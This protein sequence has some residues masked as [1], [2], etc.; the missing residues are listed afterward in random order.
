MTWSLLIWLALLQS[1]APL[2]HA[3]IHDLSIPDKIHVHSL[4]IDVN[5]LPIE[6]GL[7]QMK[8]HLADEDA[9][10]MVS[11]GKNEFDL[12][13]MNV[14]SLIAIIL[15]AFVPTLRV[16]WTVEPRILRA[17][18]APPYFLPWSLAPPPLTH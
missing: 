8:N 16:V 2:L 7:Y 17:L 6:S 3:H 5:Q 1:I 9:I 15:V 18:H 4:A 10:G 13:V 12:T 14:L 11:T